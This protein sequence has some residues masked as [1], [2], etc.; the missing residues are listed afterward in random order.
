MVTCI[1]PGERGQ[2]IGR[3]DHGLGKPELLVRR[4]GEKAVPWLHLRLSEVIDI[5][6]ASSS[7]YF[8]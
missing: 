8:S 5:S 7:R 3:A 1:D 2:C 6:C 4:A